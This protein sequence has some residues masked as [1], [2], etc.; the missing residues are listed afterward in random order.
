MKEEES[1]QCN[2]DHLF[3]FPIIQGEKELNHFFSLCTG[4]FFLYAYKRMYKICR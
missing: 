2:E 3:N 1:S 4:N